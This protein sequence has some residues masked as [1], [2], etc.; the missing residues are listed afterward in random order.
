MPRPRPVA[1]LARSISYA[2]VSVPYRMTI[3]YML[4]LLDAPQFWSGPDVHTLGPTPQS[5]RQFAP[6]RALIR[7]HARLVRSRLYSLQ[8]LLIIIIIGYVY[9]IVAV[10]V[11]VHNCIVLVGIVHIHSPYTS[12]EYHTKKQ[13]V[14]C[15]NQRPASKVTLTVWAN[16]GLVYL[17]LDV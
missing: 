5:G 13:A 15:K 4:S 17:L 7:W 2:G 3:H 1:W 6:Y 16:R 10:G 14:N 8:F 9:L 12:P 11:Q